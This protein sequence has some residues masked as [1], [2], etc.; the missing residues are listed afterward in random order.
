MSERT[1]PWFLT[2]SGRQFFPFDPRPEDVHPEDIAHSLAHLCRFQG[3][4]RSF[5]SVAQHSVYVALVLPPELKLAGLL[6]DATEAYC[7]D[8]IRPIKCQLPA[9]AEIE[10]LIWE[11][12]AERFGLPVELPAAVK[13]ADARLLQTERR[14]LL[15]PHP[16]PWTLDQGDPV[17]PYEFRIKTWGSGLA[18]R[19]FAGLMLA[20]TTGR[21]SDADQTF[22]ALGCIPGEWAASPETVAPEEGTT[23]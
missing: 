20:L 8:L 22:A 19:V 13:E 14:D 9:Y 4:C 2:Y 6:H 10:A 11:A 23:R 16:W 15:A 12:V 18:S 7:G 1:G 5:Y 3:H 21:R 17:R